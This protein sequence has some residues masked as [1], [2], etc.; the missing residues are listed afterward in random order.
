M[1]RRIASGI[2]LMMV[3]SIF[4]AASPAVASSS[5]SVFVKNTVFSH[6]IVIFSK[7]YCPDWNANYI[8][9][10]NLE[11]TVNGLNLVFVKIRPQASRISFNLSKTGT[12]FRRI[13][14]GSACGK[15]RYC[16]HAKE[17]FRELKQTPYV[18][19]LDERGHELNESTAWCMLFLTKAT[20]SCTYSGAWTHLVVLRMVVN[21]LISIRYDGWSIQ[22]ALSGIVSRRTVPQVFINGKH[23]GGSDDTV[24]AYRNGELAKLLGVASSDHKDDL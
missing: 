11:G 12:Y 18:I 6:K 16:R 17:V 21:T 24:E 1:D 22:D 7:S 8:R 15:Y 4:L 23:I 20:T 2:A 14:Y 19:E 9:F 13:I 5:E 10:H 3:L